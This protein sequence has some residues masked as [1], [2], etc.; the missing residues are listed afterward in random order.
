ERPLLIAGHGIRLG[1]AQEEF[2]ELIERLQL[3]VATALPN[4]CDLLP[5]D[6]PLYA[7]RP[8]ARASRGSNFALQNAD[9]LLTLGARLDVAQTGY[10]H[11]LWA[12]A[13]KKVVVNIDEAEIR[14]M[15]VPVDVPVAA[16]V[17]AF[18][19]EF[20]RQIDRVEHRDRSDWLARCREWKERYP[21]VLPE[22]WARA[23]RVSTYVLA[24]VLSELLTADD[25]VV[26]GSSGLAVEIFQLAFRIKPGQRFFTCS[27]LGAMGFG[28]PASIGGCL[29]SG[30]R[31]TV[32]I[33][34][35]GGFQL[36]IQELATVA[37]LGLPIK[38]FVV[39]NEGYASIRNTQK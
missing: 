6:H 8:G 19:Q 12:R 2:A 3:P 33:D 24:D 21:V 11:S 37:R 7:G 10:D 32:T 1:G 29:A 27:G 28:I 26:P 35:D 5:F 22:Y 34:G 14:K 20:L 17:K 13:A 38:Y 15:R 4:G 9:L 18:L 31:R 39:N 30:G 16:D 23:D 36:N 25:L